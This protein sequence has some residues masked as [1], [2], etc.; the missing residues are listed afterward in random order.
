MFRSLLGR[1]LSVSGARA[2]RRVA[3]I[4][5]V[6]AV[7]A[8]PYVNAGAWQQKDEARPRKSA[9]AVK[10]QAGI[11]N[12]AKPA[13]AKVVAASAKKET[14]EAQTL[15][16]CTQ[17]QPISFGQ[18]I[19]GSLTNGDCV[20]PVPKS[21]NTQPD[22]SLA[23][24]YTFNG[25]AGQQITVSMSSTAFDTYLYLLRPDG[26]VLAQN[27][28]VDPSSNPPN[29]NSRIPPN[30]FIVLPFSGTFSILASSFA[31]EARGAYTLTLTAGANC[32]LTPI[33][34]GE[35]KQGSLTVGD[36]TNPIDQDGTLV[37]LY[38]FNGT[39][40]Q[41]VSITMTT[42]AP[43]NVDPYLYLI[44]PNGDQIA[45]D[46]N[47][48]GG[49]TAHIPTNGQFGRL[50]MTGTYIIVANTTLPS[51]SGNYNLTLTKAATDCPSVPLTVGATANGTLANSDCRLLE[52]GSFLDAYTFTAA[53]NAQIALTMTSTTA[54]LTPVLFLLSPT[55]SV[56]SIDTA[57]TGS[58]TAR[59]PDGSGSFTLS[60]TGTYTVLANSLVSG[61]TGNYTL[62]L[63]RNVQPNAHTISG[64]VTGGGVGLSGVTVTLSG[65][66]SA[67]TTTDANGFYA[68]V[69]FPAGNS[70]TITPTNTAQYTFTPQTVPSL[71]TD[72]TVNFVGTPRASELI[73][74]EFR[75]FGPTGLCDEFVEIY[76][77]RSTPYIVQTADNSPG[78]AVAQSNGNVLFVIPNNTAI[79]ARGHYLAVNNGGGGCIGAYSD[80]NYPAGNGTTA[81]GDNTLNEDIA[82]NAGIALFN[83]SNQ[84]S[85]NLANRLDA[86]GTSAEANPLYKEGTGY[87]VFQ[88][89]INETNGP[90]YSIFRNAQSGLPQDTNNNETDF[91]TADE[92]STEM[93]ISTA[94]FNC[95]RLGAPGPENLSSPV[96]HNADIKASLVDPQCPGITVNPTLRSACRFERRSEQ[97][98]TAPSFGTFA[99]RRRFTNMTGAPVTRLRFRIVD[100]TNDLFLFGS[101]TA[102]I[103]AITSPQV[104]AT[105]QNESGTPHLCSDT[106]LPTT[107][108]EG[109]TR[110]PDQPFSNGGGFNSTVSAGTVTLANPLASG[111]SVN[112]QF[113]FGVQRAG[114]FRFFVNVEA[115][116]APPAALD[117]TKAGATKRAGSRKGK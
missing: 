39:A 51:Q 79:P 20:S 2:A 15:A 105:C 26:T 32:S 59:I 69:E 101:S 83:T 70:Y 18:T 16:V 109:T 34:Y 40:G 36:C 82:T 54:G 64:Q 78:F 4:V 117:A 44:Q 56:L 1:K 80:G 49:S 14:G 29:Q 41:Q 74:S 110:E 91:Q 57:T 53:A 6:F 28:D 67:T 98:G 35:T 112:L 7:A 107:T 65:G 115:L 104:T 111:G 19:N 97:V 71:Q 33:A 108:I 17:N 24:E 85:F 63:T 76:N 88:G 55:G 81:T 66:A 106:G 73:I 22:G 99:I 46:D 96:Q 23:D 12:S 42:A 47:G 94:N 95:R 58:S 103:R 37:D 60:V 84:G 102:D 86:V 10:A 31:P 92:S 75:T 90:R 38:T 8:L 89:N 87:P 62:T 43:G 116:T 72:Q 52:D 3:L 114:A 45:E 48:G 68:F 25:T 21:G 27:D 50:P 13:P 11:V 9:R 77:T 30:G 100:I 113:L 61:Q 93:C 5:S